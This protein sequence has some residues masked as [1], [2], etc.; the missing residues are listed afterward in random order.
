MAN[1]YYDV[2]LDIQR[3]TV[4][5]SGFRF[6]QGDSQ[7]IFFRIAVYNGGVPF[8]ATDSTPSLC[9]LKPDG[10]FVMGELT[11]SGN[12]WI[13][14]ILGN[15]LQAAGKVL[16][17]VKFTYESGRVSSSKFIFFVEK[18]TTSVD[19]QTSAYYIAPLEQIIKEMRDYE[20]QGYSMVEA[21]E[22][23]AR[24]GTGKR[25]DEDADNSKFYSEEAKRYKEETESAKEWVDN[26]FNY[27]M[28]EVFMDFDTGKLMYIGGMLTF[29]INKNTGYLEWYM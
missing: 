7:V 6:T 11:Q 9:F 10:N 28:P 23:W 8:D 26:A 13:Y 5:D 24:G 19:A 18:D 4:L 3:D 25:P 1:L 17:D 14:Q 20:E 12:Y 22:S 2:R 21:A 15:E 16:C 27:R 29:D